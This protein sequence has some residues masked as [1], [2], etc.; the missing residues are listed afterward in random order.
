MAEEFDQIEVDVA[1][2]RYPLVI[3]PGDEQT[4]R[5]IVAQVNASISEMQSTYGN[6]VSVER[7]LAMT[8]LN[9]AERLYRCHKTADPRPTLRA[10]ENLSTFLD[11]QLEKSE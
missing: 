10:L 11:T 4:M 9:Y 6:R 2:K 3:K 1:G 8:L 5:N 7:I